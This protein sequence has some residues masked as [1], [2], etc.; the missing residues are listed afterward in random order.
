MATARV[1]RRALA[2]AA[3]AARRVSGMWLCSGAQR[4]SKPRSSSARA[5][6]PGAME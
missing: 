3:L 5:S 1:R 6:T 2:T 4:L